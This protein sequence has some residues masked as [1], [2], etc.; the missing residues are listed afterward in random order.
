MGAKYVSSHTN[1]DLSLAQVKFLPKDTK[2]SMAIKLNLGIPTDHILDGMLKLYILAKRFNA[3]SRHIDDQL[4]L[5][6]L[7]FQEE[8]PNI[9]PID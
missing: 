7:R 8:I 6:N 2:D 1:H 9:Y 5:N 3:T 4:T